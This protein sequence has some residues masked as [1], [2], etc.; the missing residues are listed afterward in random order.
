MKDQA[1]VSLS[2]PLDQARGISK[3]LEAWLSGNLRTHV[4]QDEEAAANRGHWLLQSAIEAVEASMWHEKVKWE[5]VGVLSV[6]P[7]KK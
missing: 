6:D 7:V 5:K 3:I 4:S 1:N 2:L